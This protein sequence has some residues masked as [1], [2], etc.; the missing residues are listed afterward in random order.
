MVRCGESRRAV[1][2][3]SHQELGVLVAARCWCWPCREDL[4]SWAALMGL[5]ESQATWTFHRTDP[6][7]EFAFRKESC[8]AFELCWQIQQREIMNIMMLHYDVEFGKRARKDMQR[9]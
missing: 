7:L 5:R 8:R 9:F 6:K 2:R 4:K 1:S 3:E